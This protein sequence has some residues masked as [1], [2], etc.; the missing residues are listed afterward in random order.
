MEFI[1]TFSYTRCLG[2]PFLFAHSP[3]PSFFHLSAPGE[4]CPF[5][6]QMCSTTIYLPIITSFSSAAVPFLVSWPI[7]STIGLVASALFTSDCPFLSLQHVTRFLLSELSPTSPNTSQ[8][9]ISL[10][11]ASSAVFHILTIHPYPRGHSL[12]HPLDNIQSPFPQWT[13]SASLH[14]CL[15]ILVLHN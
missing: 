12:S 13:F 5:S 7:H 15:E 6:C 2:W 14:V 1:L 11:S 10:Y 3:H 8:P 4:P 9:L